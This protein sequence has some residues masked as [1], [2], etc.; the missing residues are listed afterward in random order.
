ME[1]FWIVD[2]SAN[3]LKQV[4]I[5]KVWGMMGEHQHLEVEDGHQQVGEH[6]EQ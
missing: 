4:T 1:Q 2:Y 6:L 5:V 3:P